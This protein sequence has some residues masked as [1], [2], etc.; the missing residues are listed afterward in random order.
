[1][2]EQM[3]E[4]VDAIHRD[5]ITIAFGSDGKTP[6]TRNGTIFN[7]GS[8]R[9]YDGNVRGDN[10]SCNSLVR[11]IT[12]REAVMTRINR[13][14]PQIAFPSTLVN[15]YRPEHGHFIEELKE[16]IFLTL[17]VNAKEYFKDVALSRFPDFSTI[18]ALREYGLDEAGPGFFQM[19]ASSPTVRQHSKTASGG[20][21]L[22]VPVEIAHSDS[23]AIEWRMG[24]LSNMPFLNQM[25]QDGL[26]ATFY[27][28]KG[29]DTRLANWEIDFEVCLFSSD[30]RSVQ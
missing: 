24:E 27:D 17:R 21:I 26:D 30:K 9:P 13:L 25:I 18:S 3:L 19:Y 4:V 11:M 1:M 6:T 12:V 23:V 14:I 20:L 2:S 15:S 7:R 22:P 5:K 16:N 28:W 29:T 8:Q 10:W